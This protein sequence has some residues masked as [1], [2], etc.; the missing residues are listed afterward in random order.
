MKTILAS[1]IGLLCALSYPVQA[2]DVLPLRDFTFKRVG[3]PTQ[4]KP[5]INVQIDPVEQA[6]LLEVAPA[7]LPATDSDPHSGSV[8]KAIG[9]FGWFWETIPINGIGPGGLDKVIATLNNSRSGPG[10]PRL[11][12]LKLIA[13]R[14]GPTFLAESVGTKVSPALALAVVAVE[15]A[16]QVEAV[17]GAGAE[18][19][20]QLMPATA[21]RFGVTDSFDPRQNIRGGITYLD[22]LMRRFE[23]DPILALAGYNAGEGA[24]ERHG[25]VPPYA[26]T[27]D[28]VPKVLA[29]FAVARGLCATPPVLISD[30]CVFV[31]E[32]MAASD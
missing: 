2:E 24:V 5:R 17:S 16:G 3:L 20:M 27:R 26:E 8:E 23:G 14:Y 15:S 30:G 19:L 10:G 4:G 18:G 21:A 6:R 22:W 25:G 11:A 31:D 12:T 32:R 7:K 9:N 1:A 29:A 28:Y 13:D